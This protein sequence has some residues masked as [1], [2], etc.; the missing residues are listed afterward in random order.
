MTG[1]KS[2]TATIFGGNWVDAQEMHAKHP[3]TFAVPTQQELDTISP[4]YN[5]KICDASERFW[6]SVISQDGQD[7][8]GQVDNNLIS[9]QPYAKVGSKVRFQTRHIYLVHSPAEPE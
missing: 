1:N 9:G 4:D 5:V 2:T 7:I 3:D 6:V 8:I